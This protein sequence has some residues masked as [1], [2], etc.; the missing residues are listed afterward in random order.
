MAFLSTNRASQPNRLGSIQVGTSEYGTVVALGYGSFKAPI[1][2]LDYQDFT[3][4]AKSAGGKGGSISSYEYSAAVDALVCIGPIAGMGNT[5]DS[6][7]SSQLLAATETW[8]IPQG[9]GT[10]YQA[11]HGGAAFWYDE[12]VTY[13]VNYS[14]S[15]NDFGSDGDVTI[16]GDQ[17]APFEKV[18]AITGQ[19]Q[20]TVSAT[21]LYQFN[22]LD[23]GISVSITYA[24]T[25]QDTTATDTTADNTAIAPIQRYGISMIPGNT[26]SMPWGYM[27]TKHPE[28]A[29]RYDGIARMVAPAM[30]LG[31]SATTP[32]LSIEVLNGRLKAFGNGVADCNPA[33]IISDILTMADAGCAWPYLG[34]MTLHS[35]FCA[36]NN[37]F[38]SP[39]YDSARKVTEMIKELCDLTN[40]D[41]LWSG[42]VLKIIPYGDTSAVGNGRTFNPP[43]E[44]VY[45]IDD[46]D[47]ICK[48]GEDPVQIEWPDLSDNYN[49]V[50]FEYTARNDNY[51]TAVIHEQDEASILMN[52]VLP[53]QTITAHHYCVQLYAAVAMNMLLR[54]MAVPLRKYTFVAK[55]YYDLMEPMDIIVVNVSTG[56]LGLTPMR[57]VSKEEQDDY[58]L[59][60]EAE[61]FFWGMA[62]G[63]QYPKGPN[64][65]NGPGTYTLPGAT[66]LLAAFQPNS[67]ITGGGAELW[68]AL[69]GGPDWGGCNVWLSLDGTNYG[70]TPIGEQFGSARAGMLTSVLPS[71]ADPDTDDTAG[72]TV[73]GSLTTVSETDADSFATLSLVGTE[74]VSYANAT[75]T[76]STGLT[77]SYNLSYLRR[78]VFATSPQSHSVGEVFVRLDDQVFKYTID[79]SLFGKTVF[80]K[81]TSKNLYGQ[82]EQILSTVSPVAVVLGG[83]ISASTMA[84][85][86]FLNSDG[87]TATVDIYLPGGAPTAGGTT[88]LPNGAIITLPPYSFSSETPGTTYYV[89]YNAATSAYAIYTDPNLWLAD[90]HAGLVPIGSTTTPATSTAGSYAFSRYSD[91]GTEPTN[92][93]QGAYAA[94]GNAVVSSTGSSTP[95]PYPGKPASS[96]QRF[97]LCSWFGVTG[98]LAAAKTLSLTAAVSTSGDSSST[99]SVS[100]TLDGSSWTTL[101]TASGTNASQSYQVP[102]PAGTN[103]AN[104]MVRAASSCYPPTGSSGQTA[105]ASITVSNLLI[106]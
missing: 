71:S 74:L 59:S 95:S 22:P 4:V 60:I 65:G 69:S 73:T 43:T 12:G 25:T 38:M 93:P 72:V 24:Y 78:G 28:N 26:P 8:T 10:G 39:F 58:S 7:G 30:D 50:I 41:S 6:G 70:D 99:N 104:V 102:I 63:V 42:N 16:S 86:S 44:P 94:G 52:G 46:D 80:L 17:P 96:S 90:Q 23:V 49:R 32:T 77:N 53:M 29:L 98:T 20:Y 3:S 54:R 91:T 35:N 55:W 62:D 47:L 15:A 31:S 89:N 33:D 66:S 83:S 92:N 87:A 106:S 34:D 67:R 101:F 56:G 82:Q 13:Q 75:L 9:D 64:G 85:G 81:F 40:S 48:A 97:G 21:G 18:A 19:K 100:V 37:L 79:P 103:L 27:A 2:L 45:V 105:Y 1:K 14:Y 88:S 51:N 68:L 76:G 57:L 11:L 36:A 5:Y 84:V 61:D